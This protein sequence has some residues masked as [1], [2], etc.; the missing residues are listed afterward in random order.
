MPKYRGPE[1]SNLNAI[2]QAKSSGKKFELGLGSIEKAQA[3]PWLHLDSG[4]TNRARSTSISAV[5][6]V[7]AAEF[8]II[9]S[10]MCKKKRF[11]KKKSQTWKSFRRFCLFIR[12]NG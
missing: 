11:R 10:E 8:V 9:C 5:V 4:S 2:V 3:L 6:A 12:L 1:E 7:A